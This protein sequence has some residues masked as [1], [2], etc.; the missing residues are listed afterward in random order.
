[1]FGRSVLSWITRNVFKDNVMKHPEYIEGEQ[2][3]ENFE[4]ATKAPFNVPKDAV[5]RAE[6]KVKNGKAGTSSGPPG[7]TQTSRSRQGRGTFA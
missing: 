4:E 2:A 6:K 1:M 3:Q 5:V 7:Y